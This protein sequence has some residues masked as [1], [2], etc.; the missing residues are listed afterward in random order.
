MEE[1]MEERSEEPE[2]GEI[3]FCVVAKEFGIA[4]EKAGTRVMVGV[5]GY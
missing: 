3:G 4:E 2:R 1:S 5:P